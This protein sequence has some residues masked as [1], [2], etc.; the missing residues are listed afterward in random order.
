MQRQGVI[1]GGCASLKPSPSL[2][3]TLK[4][5]PDG[6]LLLKVAR[7]ILKIKQNRVRVETLTVWI[8]SDPAKLRNLVWQQP[9][10]YPLLELAAR[11][12]A[13]T[14]QLWRGEGELEMVFVDVQQSVMPWTD[15]KSQ[16][17]P[18]K[19]QRTSKQTVRVN[20]IHIL[21]DFSAMS[22]LV[23]RRVR[24]VTNQW[25]WEIRRRGRGQSCY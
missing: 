24:S 13:Q 8:S 5:R 6:I 16:P 11:R 14:R 20:N 18:R 23:F 9:S 19:W 21:E 25:E 22:I 2:K 15:L 4:S 17:E 3:T 1:I 7:P 10:L 12:L